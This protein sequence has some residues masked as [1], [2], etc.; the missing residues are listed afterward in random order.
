MRYYEEKG[1]IHP[2]RLENGYRDYDKLTLERIKT[3]KLYFDLGLT[4]AE[5]Q[6]V[7]GCDPFVFPYKNLMCKDV[8]M[9]YEDKLKEVSHQIQILQQI[10][11]RLKE[12]LMKIYHLK[13]DGINERY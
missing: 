11:S 2:E 4:T 12:R 10:K 7:M 5:M 3:L 1:L 9:I 6:Q 8:I 13:E